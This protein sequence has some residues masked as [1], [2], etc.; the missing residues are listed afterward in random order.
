M[1]GHKVVIGLA[2]RQ[3]PGG[4]QPV[5]T[6]SRRANETQ[7]GMAMSELPHILVV[8]DDQRLRSLLHRYLS[9]NGFRVSE[10]ED[11]K[12]ARQR[13][14]S[15]EFDLIILDV[16]MPGE[17]GLELTMSLHSIGSVPILL[18][19]AMGRPEDRIAGLEGGADDYLPKPFEPRELL[20]RIHTILR[21][22]M[23][24]STVANIPS[25]VYFGPY[26]YDLNI[27]ELFRDTRRVKLTEAET[28]LLHALVLKAGMP[29]DRDD[30]ANNDHARTVDVQV[31]RL[32]RKL[33]PDPKFPRYLQTVRGR[34]YVLKTDR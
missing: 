2:A 17:T 19:T 21:R 28:G 20:A 33:E 5:E 32:R 13:L 7:H 14:L 23:A 22:T 16:M 34:G 10:A 27:G 3:D 29:V 12:Q 24:P 25:Q 1:R 9:E 11:A 4:T 6:I 15:V 26:R 8:D 30:L 18:L 31:A